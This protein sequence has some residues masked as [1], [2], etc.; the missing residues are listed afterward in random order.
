MKTMSIRGFWLNIRSMPEK[1]AR[2]IGRE[3]DCGLGLQ[4]G[5]WNMY[6]TCVEAF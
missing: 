2:V 1:N 6:A 5:V 3:K 4:T